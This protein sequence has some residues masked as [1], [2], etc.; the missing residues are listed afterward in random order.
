LYIFVASSCAVLSNQSNG[1]I[2]FSRFSLEDHPFHRLLKW[3]ESSIRPQPVI[4]KSYFVRQSGSK[5]FNRMIYVPRASS[6]LEYPSRKI[7]FTDLDIL[8]LPKIKQDSSNKDDF[9]HVELNDKA[10]VWVLMSA[11]NLNRKNLKNGANL[12]GEGIMDSMKLETMRIV[13]L[14]DVQRTFGLK[15]HK[16]QRFSI[17]VEVSLTPSHSLILPHPNQ[18]SVNGVEVEKYTL[19]FAQNVEDIILPF[20]E[21]SVPEPYTAFVGDEFDARPVVQPIMDIPEANKWCPTWLHDLYVTPSR[22]TDSEQKLTGEPAYW[23]TWHPMIDPYYW[24]YFDHEHGSYPGNYRPMFEYTAWKKYDEESHTGRQLESHAGFKV[25]SFQ[26]PKKHENDENR[27]VVATLH[28]HLSTVRRIS[29]RTHTM[30]FSVLNMDKDWEIEMELHFKMDF[31]PALATYANKSTKPLTEEDWKIKQEMDNKKVN[32]GR[33]INVLD[34]THFPDSVDRKFKTRNN[35][36]TLKAVSKGIYEQWK[37]T[38][39]TCSFSNSRRNFGFLFETRDPGTSIKNIESFGLQTLSGKSVN[40]LLKV[41]RV[42]LTIGLE[43]CTFDKPVKGK[44]YTDPDMT[45]VKGGFGV[46]NVRQYIKEGFEKIELPSGKYVYEN[47]WNPSMTYVN[48]GNGRF[49]IVED[50]VDGLEN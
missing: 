10:R 36:K 42:P 22:S 29:A 14:Q 30:I 27:A 28:Q 26:V 13:E 37:G 48:Q 18:I 8:I 43:Y 35:A 17:A 47:D 46:N 9:L 15:K 41:R 20:E 12:K 44:F 49:R 3:K 34:L 32:A 31:G 40:R 7:S 5:V 11:R 39:N 21:P 33:R 2:S 25:F 1:N 50:A 23:R 38:L 19:L 16:L 4:M 45:T 6:Y 24:C